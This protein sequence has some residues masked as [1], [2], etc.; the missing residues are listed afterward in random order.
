[1]SA[2][3]DPG[4]GQGGPDAEQ[5][6]LSQVIITPLQN[7]APTL[8]AAIITPPPGP[9]PPIDPPDTPPDVPMVE[10]PP[11][12][13]NMAREQ[14][15]I[16]DSSVDPCCAQD[17]SALLPGGTVCRAAN[18]VCDVAEV[19]N[20][21]TRACPADG[22]ASWEQTCRAASAGP[23]DQAEHC[24]GETKDCPDDR[25]APAGTVCGQP[26][27]P[28]DAPEV[29]DGE[30]LGCPPPTVSVAP[31]TQVCRPANG[32]C[33]GEERCDG[34]SYECPEDQPATLGKE[35]RAVNGACDAAEVCTGESFDCP[36]D[37]FRFDEVTPCRPVNPQTEPCGQAEFCL[38]ATRDCPPDQ[39]RVDVLCRAANA[40]T[41]DQPEFCGGNS[42]QCPSDGFLP[43]GAECNGGRGH[44]SSNVCCP[45][46]TRALPD[47]GG[48]TGPDG[49][50]VVFVTSNV[51]SPNIGLAG[52][53]KMCNDLARSANLAGNFRAWLSNSALR[54]GGAINRVGEGPYVRVDNLLV[55]SNKTALTSP[56]GGMQ[57]GI[58]LTEWGEGRVTGVWTG[59]NALGTTML[60][61]QGAPLTCSDW[62]NNTADVG[63]E[64]G[65]S[66]TNKPNWTQ[67]TAAGCNQQ[68]ALYCFPEAAPL[69]SGPL[70]FVT[71]DALAFLGDGFVSIA[72]GD[73]LCAE[74]AA[75][76]GLKGTW[77]AW[78]SDERTNAGDRVL[79]RAY[80]RMD[81]KRV[82]ASKADLT[83]GTLES[84]ID[85]DQFGNR[86]IPTEGGGHVW[87][88]T[89]IDGNAGQHCGNW[90]PSDALD[91]TVGR[92]SQSDA[93]WTDL[94]DA[95]ECRG[96]AR[97]YCFQINAG[98][99]DG[100]RID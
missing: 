7:E 12:C 3:T 11:V 44:C 25:L 57:N 81:G 47:G 8:P 43:A 63:G 36:D 14:G 80:F 66:D 34:V 82:A 51:T 32:V 87:T 26:S 98:T 27:M 29:C 33:D 24:T 16:C 58:S 74:A 73:Q 49:A 5:G 94:G 2:A 79:D 6:A 78:L 68:L 53:D 48:C 41:C 50:K 99:I 15:E 93:G 100:P 19:C 13:G 54:N 42:A 17:C 67:N 35:C 9:V 77:V 83:D 55:A 52:A 38:G 97:L 69:V 75:D 64:A 90:K 89:K 4:S 85:V 71:R 76:G 10:G 28:C 59:T 40:T 20:G 46:M 86:I 39:H 61:V 96:N 91:G 72:N 31:A 23:C 37:D 45:G 56:N 21:E 70:V 65:L 95:F 62:A 22:V 30:T 1:M 92:L 60:D 88:G 18:G 84:A